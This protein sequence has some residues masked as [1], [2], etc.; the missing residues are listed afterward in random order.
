M[1]QRHKTSLHL[2]AEASSISNAEMETITATRAKPGT[3][4]SHKF[5]RA[6]NKEES[7]KWDNENF[8]NGTMIYTDGSCYRNMVGASAVLY[9][10]GQEI[11]S[12]KFQLGFAS[13]HTVFEGELVGILLGIHLASKHP[14]TKASVNFSI[15]NQA[16][17]KAMQNNA[18]QPAQ[19]LID[20]IHQTTSV[21]QGHLEDE[22]RQNQPFRPRNDTR[23]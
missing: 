18:R 5:R 13:N 2:H 22:Q 1:V 10:I 4:S 17:T 23:G 3:T 6:A 21:L 8:R 12:L 15:D 14:G 20:E 9:E 16:T 7:I 19:Y 11:G